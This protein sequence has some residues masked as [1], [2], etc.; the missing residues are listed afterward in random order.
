M[1]EVR[2]STVPHYFHSLNIL[3]CIAA[4]AVVLFHWQKFFYP[5]D[6]FV[7]GGEKDTALPLYSYLS[8]FYTYSS[9]SIDIFF[10]LSGF[11]FFWLYSTQIAGG[12]TDFKK[13]A[14]YR[15][16]R[17]YPLHLVAL[18]SV[19]VL[20]LLMLQRMGH[21]FVIQYND[22]YH[23]FLHLLFIQ[24][25]G[26]EAGTS[27][28]AP[29]WS[30]SVEIL[31]YILFFLICRFKWH[32][33]KSLLLLLML[34]GAALQHLGLLI[35][36]GV[37]S[38]FLGGF[39]YYIF[40]YILQQNENKKYLKILGT[41]TIILWIPVITSHLYPIQERIWNYVNGS[42]RPHIS[43]D[44]SA[45]QYEIVR[46]FLFRVTVAPCTILSVLLLETVR[47]QFHRWWGVV[48]NCSY[49]FYLLH[50]PLQI[51]AVLILHQFHLDRNLLHSPW[52]ML[53][54]LSVLSLMSLAVYYYFER[55]AQDKIRQTAVPRKSVVAS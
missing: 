53:L 41:L 20:Q 44:Q 47:G 43:P 38:F 29:S 8:F 16:S 28:N 46:N 42:L 54:F 34:A 49:A 31:M 17:L 15:L 14:I 25:W 22:A 37:F 11:I 21:Y 2:P 48:G 10:Q 55:P 5:D 39:L 45:A 13:F 12:K 30:T 9:L 36:K 19:V 24:N 18:V 50:F 40:T 26:V 27:W 52:V 1:M 32:T 6:V 23:F 4:I 35:G 51:A 7:P 33:N 3:R